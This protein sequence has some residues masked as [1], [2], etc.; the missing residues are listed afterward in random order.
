MVFW[1][2]DEWKKKWNKKEARKIRKNDEKDIFIKS[3]KH[4]KFW[5]FISDSDN[6]MHAISL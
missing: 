6:A 2:I 1:L 5:I 3:E 4:M